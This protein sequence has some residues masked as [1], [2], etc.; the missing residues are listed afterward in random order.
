MS[1]EQVDVKHSGRLFGECDR[2][3]LCAAI[4]MMGAALSG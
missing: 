2:G 1:A 3:W 4:F